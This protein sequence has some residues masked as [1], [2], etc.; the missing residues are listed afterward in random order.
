MKVGERGAKV[1]GVGKGKF[2]LG[3]IECFR[4]LGLH[5]MEWRRGREGQGTGTRKV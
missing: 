2:G 1:K 4:F 3:R 5:M